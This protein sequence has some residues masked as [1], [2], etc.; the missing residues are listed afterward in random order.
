M[1][2]HLCGVS[3]PVHG[4]FTALIIT[5]G[6]H[7]VFVQLIYRH[8]QGS[9]YSISRYCLSSFLSVRSL[10]HYDGVNFWSNRIYGITYI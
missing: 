9:L 8:F 5:V 1:A 2:P 4:S 6:T 10:S 7:R 3:R